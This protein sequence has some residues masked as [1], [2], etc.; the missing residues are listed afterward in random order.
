MTT[1]LLQITPFDKLQVVAAAR[2]RLFNSNAI[3]NMRFAV[4]NA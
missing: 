1:Q 4:A 3:E 2:W